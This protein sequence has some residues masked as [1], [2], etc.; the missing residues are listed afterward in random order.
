MVGQSIKTIRRYK[1]FTQEKLARKLGVS[2]QAICMWE[3][4][5]RELKMSTLNRIANMLSVSMSEIIQLHHTSNTQ[6]NTGKEEGEIKQ[7]KQ[8]TTHFELK[9]PGARNVILAGD[10]NS[11]KET[12]MSTKKKDGGLWKAGVN[13]KPGKYEYK[14]IVDGEWIT[15]PTNTNT[16]NSSLGTLNS[17]K[18]VTI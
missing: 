7:K 1:K 12:K 18:E 6:N 14:F 10:F 9:A 15:D 11:W 4:G 13:L 17:V 16:T 8:K 2:R 3:S 5:K